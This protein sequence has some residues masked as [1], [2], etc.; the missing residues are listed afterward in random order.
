MNSKAK[1][2]AGE[3]EFA[4]FLTSQGFPAHRN[5]QRFLGGHDNPDVTADAL[6]DY[7]FEVKRVERLNI[8]AAME[9][10]ERDAAGRVP[11]VVHRRNRRPWL[12]TLHLADWLEVV[13][14]TMKNGRVGGQSAIP[15]PSKDGP[16]SDSRT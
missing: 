13:Q 16:S 12:V 7:H 2:S 6:N 1:G 14:W 4:A 3:R 10:A 9:Q 5:E 8:G 15:G 11:V